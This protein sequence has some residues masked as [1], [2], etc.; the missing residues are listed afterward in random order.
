MFGEAF[1]CRSNV[2][3]AGDFVLRP[4]RS[5][6]RRRQRL[7][8]QART[9]KATKGGGHARD[10]RRGAPDAFNMG[11]VS[12]GEPQALASQ[13]CR[14]LKQADTA[15]PSDEERGD[16]KTMSTPSGI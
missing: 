14:I 5:F 9:P 1:E 16:V 15:L 6:R 7:R 8:T 2:E 10:Q 11:F 12:A 3:D 4:K 13:D